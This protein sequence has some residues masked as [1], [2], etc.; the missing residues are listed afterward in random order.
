MAWPGPWDQE[1]SGPASCKCSEPSLPDP[2]VSKGAETF[3]LGISPVPFTGRLRP[4]QSGQMERGESRGKQAALRVLRLLERAAHGGAH[5]N[6][7]VLC[8]DRKLL[9]RRS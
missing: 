4:R 8:F 3:N 5:R 7:P 9:I 6:V 2:L 1:D